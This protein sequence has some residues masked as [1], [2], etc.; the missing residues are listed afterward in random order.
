[1]GMNGQDLGVELPRGTT[2]QVTKNLETAFHKDGNNGGESF[3][4]S[5]GDF[6]GGQLF[7]ED[8]HGNDVERV[9]E[10]WHIPPAV[11]H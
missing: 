11:V 2:L 4:V 10:A 1:M 3:A 5:L 7:C 6:V 8:E 9:T